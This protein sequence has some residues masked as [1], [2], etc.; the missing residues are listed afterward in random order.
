M[1]HRLARLSEIIAIRRKETRPLRLLILIFICIIIALIIA[2]ITSLNSYRDTLLSGQ[3]RRALDHAQIIAGQFSIS[4]ETFDKIIEMPIDK[5]I[6]QPETLHFKQLVS[7]IVTMPGISYVYILARVNKEDIRYSYTDPVLAAKR[8]A[9]VGQ[10][11]DCVYVFTSEDESGY[12]D[13]DKYDVL[14]QQLRQKYDRHS[15]FWY[16]YEDMR[17][18]T[19]LTALY[20][21]FTDGRF[22][23][24]V[25]V[26]ISIDS[27]HLELDRLSATFWTFL[28]V[29]A[30]IM[31]GFFILF[32]YRFRNTLY[33]DALTGLLN[34]NIYRDVIIR[35]LERSKSRLSAFY[36]MD[37]DNFKAIND[38]YG[39]SAG[40][41]LLTQ[42]GKRLLHRMAKETILV[43]IA[44][45]EFGIFSQGFEC[46]QEALEFGEE[47]ISIIKKEAFH[48]ESQRVMLRLSVGCAIWKLPAIRINQLVEY[49]DFAMYQAKS[50]GGNQ[51]KM[52]SWQEW[53][54]VQDAKRIQKEVGDIIRAG[55]YKHLFQPIVDVQ[56]IEV[57][58]YEGL[59]RFKETDEDDD[60]LASY[61]KVIGQGPEVER[62]LSCT[63]A[64][65]FRSFE[66]YEYFLSIN[67]GTEDVYADMPHMQYK[68]YV[69]TFRGLD[70][71]IEINEIS[72]SQKSKALNKAVSAR[73][74]GYH[75]A[76]DDF[77]KGSRYATLLVGMQPDF[78][79]ISP[80][81]ISGVENRLEV[82]RFVRTTIQ[83]AHKLGCKVIAVGVETEDALKLL[84]KMGTDYLQGFIVGRPA[85]TLLGIPQ[86]IRKLIE[87]S[88]K[89]TKHER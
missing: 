9:E 4:S 88:I 5:S 8:G 81:M 73:S 42:V 72:S 47:L 66:C 55:E 27:V 49:A 64:N 68:D 61:L 37:L 70:I 75:V 23:G 79:K 71:V 28:S 32:F 44:G 45:D 76:L 3:S 85:E 29:I 50:K 52:F 35:R 57:A 36:F 63:L 58:G 14:D 53:C 19:A 84:V 6:I 74:M 17:W 26:D 18:E 82:Q 80:D 7:E 38:N 12:S 83:F 15:A 34:R 86:N 31:I 65:T 67:E 54:S 41:K 56:R 1:M 2:G 39:H 89:E 11:M 62:I 20:P 25:G 33:R 21:F 46:E 13:K 43:R 59:T 22:S 24:Y 69:E 48:V 16:G 78:L 77:A 40:D 87:E 51:I 30:I 10:P 60:I